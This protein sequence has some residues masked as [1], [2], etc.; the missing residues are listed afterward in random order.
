MLFYTHRFLISSSC[1]ELHSVYIY[2]TVFFV[3]FFPLLDMVILSAYASGETK[4]GVGGQ[5]FK[6]MTRYF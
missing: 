4:T 5:G 3:L 6:I 2:T 1:F